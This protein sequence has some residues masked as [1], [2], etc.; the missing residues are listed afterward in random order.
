MTKLPLKSLELENKGMKL[1]ICALN[2]EL[3]EANNI[4][5]DNHPLFSLG[6]QLSK[7]NSINKRLSSL[8]ADRFYDMVQ[9]V[10]P[11][12]SLEAISLGVGLIVGGLLKILVVNGSNTVSGIQNCIPSPSNLRY[13]VKKSHE[14]A[15]M[16]I[17]GFVCRYPCRI[18]CDI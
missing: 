12:A 14:D 7:L 4:L 11:K 13:V 1:T 8:A 2:A 15:F 6:T 17:A 18:S 5:A 9:A 16:R 10:I 3:S